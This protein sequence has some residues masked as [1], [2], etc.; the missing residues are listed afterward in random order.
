M[1]CYLRQL[2]GGHLESIKK[3]IRGAV[4]PVKCWSALPIG[5][6]LFLQS[7]HFSCFLSLFLAILPAVLQCSITLAGRDF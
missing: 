5:T 2:Y 7:G 6:I 4:N 1:F 3:S